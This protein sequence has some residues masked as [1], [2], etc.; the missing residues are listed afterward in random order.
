MKNVIKRRILEVLLSFVIIFTVVSSSYQNAYAN[1]I[2]Y[3]IAE[4]AMYLAGTVLAGFGISIG[5]PTESESI[6]KTKLGIIANA[7]MNK[8]KA[9]WSE[10]DVLLYT[11]LINKMIPGQVIQLTT[12]EYRLINTLAHYVIDEYKDV[13]NNTVSVDTGYIFNRENRLA[14]VDLET[15]S[16]TVG[17][18]YTSDILFDFYINAYRDGIYRVGWDLNS[19]NAA[20]KIILSVGGVNYYYQYNYGI[21]LT[22]NSS[23]SEVSVYGRLVG[24]TNHSTKVYE[25]NYILPKLRV[26]STVVTSGQ[27][28]Y[29]TGTFSIY[30]NPIDVNSTGNMTKDVNL[31]FDNSVPL[32]ENYSIPKTDGE[33]KLAVPYALSDFGTSVKTVSDVIPKAGTENPPVETGT[34]FKYPELKV[35]ADILKNKFPFSIP[36]DLKNAVISLAATPEAPKW[37]INFPSNY[38]VGGG[39]IVIDFSQ[40]EVWARII[41]WGILIT[42]NIFLILATRKIVGAS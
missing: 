6:R 9:E 17:S 24:D 42:F 34:E 1:P 14:R 22:Y 15:P 31:T 27:I 23:N 3:P 19:L 35:P 33:V 36:W 29:W 8:I 16:L 32:D 28:G 5:T 37:T 25:T 26:G 10:P 40:F 2:L 30:Y 11:A 39:Q 7:W 41:R 13:P 20:W 38:F 12:D 18:V 4:G 21:T